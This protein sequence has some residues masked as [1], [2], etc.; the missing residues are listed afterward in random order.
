MIYR[1]VQ[2]FNIFFL[3]FMYDTTI[4]YTSCIFFLLLFL[5]FLNNTI[6]TVQCVISEN[7][8]NKEGKKARHAV[9]FFSFSLIPLQ[10]IS[11][12]WLTRTAGYTHW[13]KEVTEVIATNFIVQNFLHILTRIT[14]NN[15]WNTNKIFPLQS[16]YMRYKFFFKKIVPVQLTFLFYYWC[17]WCMCW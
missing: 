12:S 14:T 2:V 15:Y 1:Y 3:K 13:C 7:L 11:L 9:C 17:L 5:A 8:K 16:K 4:F 10:K 6:K